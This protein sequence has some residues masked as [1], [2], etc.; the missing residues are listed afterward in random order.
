MF[1]D[2]VEK[3]KWRKKNFKKKKNFRSFFVVVSHLLQKWRRT[4]VVICP[5][6]KQIDLQDGLHDEA[7]RSGAKLHGLDL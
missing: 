3:N 4:S 6:L 5:D 7:Y 2:E 1:F